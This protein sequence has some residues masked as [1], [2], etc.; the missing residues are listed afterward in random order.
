MWLLRKL[1]FIM[2]HN[3]VIESSGVPDEKPVTWPSS[4][5]A[6]AALSEDDYCLTVIV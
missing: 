1:P 5:A 4:S 2:P 3:N 6:A